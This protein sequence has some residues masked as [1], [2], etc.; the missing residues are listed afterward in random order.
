M[1]AVPGFGAGSGA[2]GTSAAGALSVQ[3]SRQIENQFLISWTFRALSRWLVLY[4][5]IIVAG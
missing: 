4:Q 1:S 5:A 3:P 2:A